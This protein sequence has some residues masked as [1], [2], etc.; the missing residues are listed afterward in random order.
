MLR[1]F[2]TLRR[3]VPVLLWAVVAVGC[4]DELGGPQVQSCDLTLPV[5]I[6]EPATVEYNVDADNATV[7]SVTFTTPVGDSTYTS[8]PDQ[9]GSTF[10]FDRNVEFEDATDGTLEAVGE[11][12][13][14]GAIVVSFN[15]IPTDGSQI[16]QNALACQG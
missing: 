11:A 16:S 5:P 1:H 12:G 14:G 13:T 9:T 15:V 8:F 6:T 3:T 7:A 10:E 2:A 4:G